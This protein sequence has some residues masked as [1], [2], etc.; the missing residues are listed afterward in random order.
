MTYYVTLDD[1]NVII[2]EE[3]TTS[4]ELLDI[5]MLEGQS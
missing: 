4:S 3:M 5:D 2:I 1:S